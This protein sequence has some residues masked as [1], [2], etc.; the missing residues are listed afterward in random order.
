M[1]ES[2][3]IVSDNLLDIY[4]KEIREISLKK[5]LNAEDSSLSIENFSFYTSVAAVFSSKIEGE[6]I[7]LDSYVKY[8]RFGVSF[9]PD[10]TRKTDDLYN[11]YQFAKSNVLNKNNI[12][13]AHTILSQHLLHPSRQGIARKNIMYVLAPNGAIEYVAAAP[14]N[15]ED[16]LKMFYADLEYLLQKDLSLQEVFYYAAYL[17]LVFVKI[18][19]F[20]DGN[21]RISRLIEKWFLAAKLGRKAWF[22]ES[23]KYYYTHHETYYKNLRSLGV[24][25]EELNYSASLPFLKMLA[26][27]IG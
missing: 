3:Q 24:E 1:N 22:I 11:A 25:Y 21:G 17:H 15:L 16:A 20:E 12:E 6:N 14:D 13:K 8:K 23:E 7:E 26:E 18:H 27:S 9:Q 19:P 2:L 10:Y 5:Y 4:K